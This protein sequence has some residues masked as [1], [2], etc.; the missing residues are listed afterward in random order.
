MNW[1]LRSGMLI[2]KEADHRSVSTDDGGIARFDPPIPGEGLVRATVIKIGGGGNFLFSEGDSVVI[3]E[4]AGHNIADAIVD[5]SRLNLKLIS[6]DDVFAVIPTP[7][8]EIKRMASSLTPEERQRVESAVLEKL[9][10]TV[11]AQQKAIAKIETLVE[12]LTT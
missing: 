8:Q 3:R 2:V 7:E 10:A 11:A 6:A 5:A 4:R 12:P 9:A 1:I